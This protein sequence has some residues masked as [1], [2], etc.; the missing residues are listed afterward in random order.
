MT[1][2]VMPF[3]LKNMGETYQRMM[4]KVFKYQIGKMTNVYMEYI[5]IKSIENSNHVTHL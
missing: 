4:N 1:Y 3:G 2:K 5:I